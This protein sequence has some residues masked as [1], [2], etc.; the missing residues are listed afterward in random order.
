MEVGSGYDV[1]GEGGC[2][3]CFETRN[4]T[5]DVRDNHFQK[6]MGKSMR[7]PFHRGTS[8]IQNPERERV[9]DCGPVPNDAGDDLGS[10]GMLTMKGKNRGDGRAIG[11][12]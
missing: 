6:F 4:I 11:T 8:V 9:I 12:W 2:C 7:L 1:P 3:T 10:Y 5:D